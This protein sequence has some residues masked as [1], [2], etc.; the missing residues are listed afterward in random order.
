VDT[1]NGSEKKNGIP[2][3]YPVDCLHFGPLLRAVLGEYVRM[4]AGVA[5][6]A[7]AWGLAFLVQGG[8]LNKAV[9]H[10][11]R[12]AKDATFKVEKKVIK[13]KKKTRAP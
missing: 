2:H 8:G 13:K 12:S 6:P 9:S 5:K 3:T 10:N 11:H 1:K 7:I 4:P